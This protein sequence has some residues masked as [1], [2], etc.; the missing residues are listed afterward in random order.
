[1]VVALQW[2]VR[3][4]FFLTLQDHKKNTPKQKHQ[5]CYSPRVKE[6][7]SICYCKKNNKK[8]K[9][10]IFTSNKKFKMF[11]SYL[12]IWSFQVL[13]LKAFNVFTPKAC[14]FQDYNAFCN[15]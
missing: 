10:S 6:V 2:K 15:L 12:H 9:K 4:D 13:H 3:I 11:S 7:H 5:L 8:N 1:M 14:D